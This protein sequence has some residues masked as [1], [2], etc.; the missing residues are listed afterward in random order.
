M[1]WHTQHAPFGAFASFTLGRSGATGGFGQSL[2]GAAGQR[3]F[4]GYRPAGGAWRLLPFYPEAEPPSG[5]ASFTGEVIDVTKVTVCKPAPLGPDEF[6]RELGWASDTWRSGPLRFT[7]LTPFGPVGDPA[8]LSPEAARFAFAPLVCAELA[9]DNRDGAGE[10]ELLFGFSDPA[11]PARLLGD[12]APDLAGFAVKGACG[13]AAHP[14]DV[15]EVRQAFDLLDPKFRDHRGAHLLG[16]ESGL[17]FRVPAGARRTIPLVLGFHH[18][19]PA[20]TGLPTRYF[21][22]R[23]FPDL[24][25]V[26]RHGLAAHAR[27]AALAAERDRELAESPLSADQRW[28]LAQATHSYLGSTQLLDHRGRPLWVV[29]EGEYRM[30]NT[31][32]LAA[33]HLFFELR[34]FPWAVRNVLDQFTGRYS[35]RDAH[36]LSFTHDMGV[37]DQFSP[38]GRSSYE[39][40]GLTGCFSHM[41]MEQ[42]VNW[43]CCAATYALRTGDDAWLARRRA[44]LR[45]CARSLRARDAARARA[46]DGLLKRDSDRC[47]GGAEI[48]TYDSLD[49][50]LGQA[51]NNLYLA[52]KTLAAWLLLE[53]AFARL[54]LEGDARSAGRTADTL[55]RTLLDR[56]EPDTGQ[57]PAVFEAG[58]RSRILP[59]VEGLVFPLATGDAEALRRRFPALLAA[60]ESHLVHALRAGVCLTPEGGWRLSSTSTNTWM[61]KIFLAQHVVR[62][63]F[64]RAWNELAARGDAAHVRWQQGDAVGRH[65]FTDQIRCTD[66]GDLGSRYY[67][68]GVTAVLWLDEA[69]RPPAD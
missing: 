5:E 19:G 1:H 20:T 15:A 39:C 17:L 47:A 4:V 27:Y 21:Y 67:P 3:V 16:S 44:V 34:W 2:G 8:T 65:A 48:T 51:R 22:T 50:S 63:L 31:F 29:N 41:T 9:C 68:R 53:R 46:R 66:G 13:F 62:R 18:A 6:R 54:G 45:A 58:N 14:A 7:L 55:A 38:P 61:S 40:D 10:V 12:E 26:L 57:F 36:G 32:D 69:P 24:A 60:Y 37:C 35:Y 42:L 52:G 56:F 43:V 30:I 33:D 11:Q 23:Y 64:P 49:A 25:S 28:L 59:A